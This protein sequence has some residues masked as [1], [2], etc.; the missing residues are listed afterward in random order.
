MKIIKWL[1]SENF[2]VFLESNFKKN[3][4]YIFYIQT[5]QNGDSFLELCEDDGG[6][7]VEQKALFAERNKNHI[8]QTK[9]D[10]M[11]ETKRFIK[12]KS[13]A[14][15]NESYELGYEICITQKNDYYVFCPELNKGYYAK[16]SVFNRLF[17][18]IL[19]QEPWHNDKFGYWQ[20]QKK[21]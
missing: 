20:K 12:N 7:K 3:S 21:I 15:K 6:I 13:F 19:C 4:K 11:E 14:S 9:A 18:F 10:L 1:N 5:W 8:L 2:I 16:L 17:G